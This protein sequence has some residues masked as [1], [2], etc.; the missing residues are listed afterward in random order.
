MEE[1]RR[2]ILRE[3][4]TPVIPGLGFPVSPTNWCKAS[5]IQG[6]EAAQ[7]CPGAPEMSCTGRGD[8]EGVRNQVQEK[9]KEE[10]EGNNLSF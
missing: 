8:G 3:L 5:P 7:C 10:V 2:Y 1:D 4:K 9:V 6:S